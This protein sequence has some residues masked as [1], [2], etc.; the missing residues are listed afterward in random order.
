[1]K[2]LLICLLLGL[3]LTGCGKGEIYTPPTPDPSY[4]EEFPVVEELPEQEYEFEVI[5]EDVLE[6][7]EDA[8]DVRNSLRSSDLTKEEKREM[9]NEYLESIQGLNISMVERYFDGSI[10]LETF[11]GYFMAQYE[12][13]TNYVYRLQGED[14]ETRETECY[15]AYGELC[16]ILVDTDTQYNYQFEDYKEHVELMYME[17]EMAKIA[18]DE[19][20]LNDYLLEIEEGY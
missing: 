20:A 18:D 16:K 4:E 2:K 14:L 15:K 8:K 10:T 7:M 11:D 1:M 17:L 13:C 3:T 19:E 6:A 9:L 12:V 5:Y